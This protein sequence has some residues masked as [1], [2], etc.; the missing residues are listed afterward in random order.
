MGAKF[1]V[2][3]SSTGGN[4]RPL[5][6]AIV[7][8]SGSGKT[9]LAGE[10]Q[11][12]LGNRAARL[13]QDE[14]YFDRSHLSAKRRALVNFDH[15]RSIDWK[16][17][18][19]V[20]NACASG[21]PAAVP[22]YDFSTHCQNGQS[23]RLDPP[24]FLLVEG[25]WLLRKP[26]LRRRFDVSIFIDCPADLRLDQRLARDTAERGRD[27]ES[28]RRQFAA[29][30]IP[31]HARFVEKQKR[32]ADRILTCPMAMGEIAGIAAELKARSDTRACSPCRPTHSAKLQPAPL[33]P[34]EL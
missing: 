12:I 4:A 19:S 10:L 20:L 22:C 3:E 17:L 25:L 23:R 16:S 2:N 11:K 21:E 30:V 9:W 15:P 29:T 8:G 33:A 34:L 6:I 26:A 14:F 28:V 24:D 13:S 18:E 31:M 7:G 27:A 5:L 1:M 32:W